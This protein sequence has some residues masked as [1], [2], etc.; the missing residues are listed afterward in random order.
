MSDCAQAQFSVQAAL[1]AASSKKSTP[2]HSAPLVRSPENQRDGGAQPIPALGF[3]LQ[4]LVADS[5]EGVILRFPPALRG[6]PLRLEP[7]AALQAVESRVERALPNLQGLIRGA[8]NPLHNPIA[9][10]GTQ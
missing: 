10:N 1:P 5:C 6:L 2:E 4:T 9:V 7:T 8:L 3:G